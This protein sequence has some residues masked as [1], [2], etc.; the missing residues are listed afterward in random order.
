MP[1]IGDRFTC[2]LHKNGGL[3]IRGLQVHRYHGEVHDPR[4][5]S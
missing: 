2:R 4:Y 1:H 5:D 3:Y